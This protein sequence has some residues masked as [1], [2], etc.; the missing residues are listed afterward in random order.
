MQL[1]NKIYV[2]IKFCDYYFKYQQITRRP[3]F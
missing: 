2:I 3:N 1:L